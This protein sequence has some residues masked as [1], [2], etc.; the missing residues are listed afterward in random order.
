M[1][2]KLWPSL[3]ASQG[4]GCEC[5]P[6][7]WTINDTLEIEHLFPLRNKGKQDRLITLTAI[8]ARSKIAI[9][10]SPAGAPICS[11]PG[12]KAN[13]TVSKQDFKAK[14]A[15]LSELKDVT[16]RSWKLEQEIGD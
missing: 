3:S 12:D 14:Y 11:S 1:I 4:H 8:V 10:V 9:K 5:H 13:G 7:D 16:L 15:P 6:N 2:I